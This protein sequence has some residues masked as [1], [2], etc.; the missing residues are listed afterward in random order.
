MTQERIREVQLKV[1]ELSNAINSSIPPIQEKTR[2]FKEVIDKAAQNATNINN[3]IKRIDRTQE[4]ITL[5]LEKLKIAKEQ[6]TIMTKCKDYFKSKDYENAIRCVNQM[7]KYNNDC[8]Q[9][10]KEEMLLIERAIK[11][12]FINLF[13]ES[14]EKGDMKQILRYTD[15]LMRLGYPDEGLNQYI[16]YYKSLILN[17]CTSLKEKLRA[18]SIESIKSEAVFVST[19][20]KYVEYVLTIVTRQSTIRAIDIFQSEKYYILINQL[21]NQINSGIITLIN[22]FISIRRV[23]VIVEQKPGK[24]KEFPEHDC[25]LILD[26]IA[27]FSNVIIYYKKYINDILLTIPIHETF[28]KEQSTQ[29]ETQ[30][31]LESELQKL[32]NHFLV[33]E[34]SYIQ[35][36]LMK[37]IQSRVKVSELGDVIDVFF[38][39]LQQSIERVVLTNNYQTICA[40]INEYVTLINNYFFK[41]I[42][43]AIK[44]STGF[45]GNVPPEANGYVDECQKN[46]GRLYDILNV[47]VSDLYRDNVNVLE[48]IQTV[49]DNLSDSKNKFK[50]ESFK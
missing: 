46:I 13:Q 1:N 43:N 6:K 34:K 35:S 8:S 50:M 47:R 9:R 29:I 49:L 31:E 45:G 10:T 3:E 26:E 23:K 32:L 40:V 48:M 25:L 24:D 19:V 30:T 12:E 16:N 42:S 38:F 22:E 39:V 11:E 44:S 17:E 36:Y 21:Y 7:K 5:V 15:L 20:K 33:L 37:S 28:R 14:T 18:L 41:V 2:F 4:R 27:T